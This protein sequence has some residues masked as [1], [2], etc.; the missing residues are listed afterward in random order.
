MMGKNKKPVLPSRTLHGKDGPPP[1]RVI[2]GYQPLT[3]E[4]SPIKPP[5]NPPKIGKSSGKK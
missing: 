4:F 1:R 5:S 3:G 2:G